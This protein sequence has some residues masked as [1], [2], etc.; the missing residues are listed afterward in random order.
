MSI[1]DKASN[2][3]AEDFFN[4]FNVS[5]ETLENLKSYESLL[6]KWQSKKNLISNNTI[7]EIWHRHIRDS[8]QLLIHIEN[9]QQPKILLDLGS[10][11]GFPGLVLAIMNKSF[12]NVHLLESNQNK[13]IFLAEIARLTNTSVTI[14]CRRIEDEAIIKAD[15]ITAR[16]LASLDRLLDL[17]LPYGHNQTIYM[18]HKGQNHMDE[19]KAVKDKYN[20]AIKTIVSK[21]D[22]GAV[23]VIISPQSA[24]I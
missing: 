18:F 9:T 1:D 17:A 8:A 16:A 24:A 3:G 6:K 2:Y 5:R 10:G 21:T 13:C 19:I 20:V 22:C 23:I 7:A 12:I 11:A 4:E 14:H 15:I